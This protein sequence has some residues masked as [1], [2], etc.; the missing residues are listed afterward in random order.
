MLQ[1]QLTEEEINSIYVYLDNFI[2][3]LTVEEIKFW[4]SLL[5]EQ[6]KNFNEND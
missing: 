5:E 6:D 4:Y 2:D 1:Q 3:Q